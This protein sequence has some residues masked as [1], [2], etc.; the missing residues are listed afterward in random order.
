M[1]KPE[2]FNIKNAPKEMVQYVL[3]NVKDFESRYD[4][5]L[6]VMDRERCPLYY[7]DCSLHDDIHEA[8]AMWAIDQSNLTDEEF[9]EF[10]IEEIFG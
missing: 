9:E 2:D 6:G 10:D 8:M 3:D 4:N 7:A 1:Y 5:A